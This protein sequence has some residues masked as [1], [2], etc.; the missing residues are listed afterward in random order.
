M[1]AITPDDLYCI[2]QEASISADKMHALCSAL[3]TPFPPA[4]GDFTPLTGKTELQYLIES[5]EG[6]TA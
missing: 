2:Y 5:Y 1:N 3:G 6:E 4:N